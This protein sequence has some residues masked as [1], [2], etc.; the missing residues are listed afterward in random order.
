[1]DSDARMNEITN[2]LNA[3]WKNNPEYFSD[4]DT[5]NKMFHYNERNDGQKALL[6]SYWK[7]KEGMDTAQKYTT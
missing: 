4:R 5:Y 7:K 6:D 2:N 3:Y 1:L